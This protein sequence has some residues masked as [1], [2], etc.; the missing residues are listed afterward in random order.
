MDSVTALVGRIIGDDTG[1]VV[2]MAELC[3]GVVLVLT[4]RQTGTDEHQLSPTGL[5]LSSSVV[6]PIHRL[7]KKTL[8]QNELYSSPEVR[9]SHANGTE[10]IRNVC[11]PLIYILASP[12]FYVTQPPL[13]NSGG[14]NQMFRVSLLPACAS[15]KASSNT[16]RVHQRQIIPRALWTEKVVGFSSYNEC[17]LGTEG[18]DDI[19]IRYVFGENH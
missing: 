14:P 18:I 2:T 11:S 13:P 6:A 10:P 16:M 7:L 5:S 1:N 3:C 19:Y 12:L 9:S 8:A 4:W 15:A 17:V